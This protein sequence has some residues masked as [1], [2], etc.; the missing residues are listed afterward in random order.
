M[1]APQ[2][3]LKNPL[4]VAAANWHALAAFCGRYCR[5]GC[6][7]LLDIGSTTT[8]II[9]L[10]EGKPVARGKTDTERL[11]HGEMVYTGVERTPVCA[12]VDR[13]PYRERS[14][15]VAAEWFATTR[16][17]YLILGEF[18]ESGLVNILGGCCGTT[19]EHIQAIAEAVAN[20]A[21][22]EIPHPDVKMR[23]SGLEPFVHA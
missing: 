15:G 11:I 17:V 4:S 1:V 20:V 5:S 22:R 9:P 23:L 2:I 18:A 8:D 10:A 16:D 21:P 19:P 13:V 6:G 12:I 3:A 14:V 7:L